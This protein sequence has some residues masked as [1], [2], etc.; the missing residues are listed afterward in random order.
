MWAILYHISGLMA[1]EFSRAVSRARRALMGA[2][3]LCAVTLSDASIFPLPFPWCEVRIALED[4]SEVGR[5]L[6]AAYAGDRLYRVDSCVQVLFG[7]LYA[8]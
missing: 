1:H 7:Q 3:M 8:R 6:I 5:G 2:P 4:A